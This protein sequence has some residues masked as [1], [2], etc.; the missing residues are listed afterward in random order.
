MMEAVAYSED[1]PLKSLDGEKKIAPNTGLLLTPGTLDG[2]KT[3]SSELKLVN[4]VTSS[5]KSLEVPLLHLSS[6]RT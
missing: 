5:L 6:R 3:G 2:E 4:A 1:M